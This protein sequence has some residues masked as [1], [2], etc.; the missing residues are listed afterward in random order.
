MTQLMD[1]QSS[2][3]SN[4]QRLQQQDVVKDVPSW[5]VDLRRAGMAR[6][7]QVGF[8][9]TKQEEWRF[10]N[11][12]P[13]AQKAKEFRLAGRDEITGAQDALRQHTFGKDA[14]TEIVF[15]NGHYRPDLSKVA[16]L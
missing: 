5:L 12:A 7:D 4:L 13:I 9:T 2:D 8:P 15:V 3:L 1:V 6:F 16:R 10:T 11:V 14:S